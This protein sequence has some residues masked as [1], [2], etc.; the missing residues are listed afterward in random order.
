MLRLTVLLCAAI[1]VT[2]LIAGEDKGQM[3]PGLAA[4]VAQGEE[5]VVLERRRAA[6]VPEAVPAVATE[7]ATAAPV[8]ETAV[9]VPE[10]APAE[11]EPVA[12]RPVTPE[13]VFTLSALPTVT[14]DAAPEEE[15]IADAPAPVS[16]DVWYVNANSVNVRE[17]PSTET[18]IVDKL[19]RGEAVTVAF[20]EGSEW[21]LVSIEG[22]GMEGYVALRFLTPEA[23]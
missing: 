22:D 19:T 8:V 20:E 6:P 3:R 10:A 4:A 5:I 15:T 14:V 12:A 11:P 9:F 13:P 2:L 7:P 18:S 16:G 17:G 1:F 23:P 21:A